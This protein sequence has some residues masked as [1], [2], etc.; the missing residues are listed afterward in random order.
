MEASFM[1]ALST[2]AVAAFLVFSVSCTKESKKSDNQAEIG[3]EAQAA[4]VTA[5]AAEQAPAQADELAL[6][7]PGGECGGGGGEGGSCCG[8][9]GGEGGQGGQGGS[10]CGGSGG[11]GPAQGAVQTAA[12]PDDAVWTTFKVSGMKCGNCAKRI[13]STLAGVDGVLGVTADHGAG[14]VKI[15]TAP[16]TDDVRAKIAP[17]INE[18][19]YKVL[20]I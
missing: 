16:G 7:E 10:C 18:L 2:F 12:V 8:G 4:K 20:D 11:H 1:K 14:E 3:A 17:R 13:Q 9:G 15:A 19:G 6:A 5:Q